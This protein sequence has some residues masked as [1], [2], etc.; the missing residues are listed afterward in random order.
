MC[1]VYMYSCTVQQFIYIY[2]NGGNIQPP[3]D[4]VSNSCDVGWS[5]DTHV[6]WKDPC[7]DRS[8]QTDDSEREGRER[9]ETK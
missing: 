1:V 8:N 2:Y 4:P 3:T 6:A 9:G 5:S 7:P